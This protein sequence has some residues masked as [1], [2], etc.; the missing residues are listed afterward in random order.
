MRHRL[1]S[2][3]VILVAI[4]GVTL[5]IGS[6]AHA[7][8]PTSR[9]A[10][11]FAV[12]DTFE[13]VAGD[14][15][16]GRAKDRVHKHV[17]DAMR[18]SQLISE[19]DVEVWTGDV[20]GR[21]LGA[22][23]PKGSKLKSA[24]VVTQEGDDQVGLGVEIEDSDQASPT[25]GPVA[26]SYGSGATEHCRTIWFTNT[27]AG[28]TSD[29]QVYDCYQKFQLSSTSYI[30][31]RYSKATV[32]TT[33]QSIRREVHEFTI[34]FREAKGYSRLTGGPYNYGPLPGGPECTNTPLQF[35]YG[36]VTIPLQSC[37]QIVNL[38]GGSYYQSGTRYTGHE[39]TQKYIDS[40]A[41]YS[42]T[43]SAVPIWS[44]YVWLTIGV[45]GWIPGIPCYN[46][47]NDWSDVW[48]DGLWYR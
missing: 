6:P 9:G 13:H 39:P 29:D 10:P 38:A 47:N 18:R 30:Y 40:Y 45:C 12:V 28:A 43:G 35:S 7:T 1:S 3:F 15:A 11:K 22:I 17:D 42:A 24:T 31:N 2:P 34:R 25:P 23:L 37:S 14:K 41:R 26:H 33:N 16:T 44:D 19:S 27:T 32:G 36:W 4:A 8:A 48:T 20:A 21:Q 46:N 5:A